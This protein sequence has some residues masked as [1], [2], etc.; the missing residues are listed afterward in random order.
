[1]FLDDPLMLSLKM[2]EQEHEEYARDRISFN[3]QIS[4]LQGKA[5]KA[6]KLNYCYYCKKEVSSFC[7]SHSVP[8]FCLRRIAVDGKVYYANTLINLP[9]LCDEQGVNQAGTFQIICRDC[10]SKIF[11][12]YEDPSAYQA[13]P[14]GQMLAQIAMK[15]YLQ[16][17]YKRLYEK[18]LYGLMEAEL[19]APS[20]HTE[21]RQNIIALDLAEYNSALHRAQKASTGK[22]DDWY[23][24]CYYQKLNYTVPVAFQGGIV[25]VC[26][27]EDNVI[28]DIYNTKPDYHTKEIHISVFPLEHESVIMIFIDQRDNRYRKFYRQLSKLPLE[29]QL[30]AINYI[31][32]SYSENVYLSKKLDN[33]IFENEK[34]ISACQ[35]TFDVFGRGPIKNLLAAAISEFSLKKRNE[36]PNLLS[37]EFSLG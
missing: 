17:I 15:N 30:S 36:V 24:L 9:V 31:I 7:N 32:F 13:K 37:R 11:Q 33:S 2:S 34:L 22:H 28:N 26:D 20:R 4:R 6:S 3:K 14:T 27:F 21:H 29:E 35:K 1:M 5:R 8:E 18:E 12:Q 10:D 23:Y 16:M 19:G 25:M